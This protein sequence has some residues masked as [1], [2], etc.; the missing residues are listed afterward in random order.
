MS[1]LI[2]LSYDGPFSFLGADL[3]E[4]IPLHRLM[5]V[6]GVSDYFIAGGYLRDR[7]NKRSFKDIDVFL[8]GSETL[9]ADF[10]VL[11]YDLTTA[12]TAYMEDMT[13][14]NLIRL[15]H[16]HDLE[17]ILTRMDIGLCQI[18]MGSDGRLH[19]TQAYLDDVQARRV[20]VLHSPEAPSDFDHIER[21][22]R[23]YPDFQL[24]NPWAWKMETA[25][26]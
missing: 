8:P 1:K 19:A 23:K 6:L 10:P 18:G 16:A 2:Q 15:G 12:T 4:I 11:R 13:E 21:V 14:L 17:S 22:A 7:L 9:P 25:Y 24:V 20:T 5:G 26:A 3:P